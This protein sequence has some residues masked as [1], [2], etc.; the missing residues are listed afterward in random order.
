MDEEIESVKSE[1]ESERDW[2]INEFNRMKLIYRT[3]EGAK[4]F[5]DELKVYLRMTIPT[6]YAHWE[7]YCV[8][9]FKILINFIN[10]KELKYNEIK[11]NLLTH[12][13][14]SAYNKLKGKQS[15]SQRC[16][17]TTLFIDL[18][19]SKIKI[20]NRVDTKSNL[21]FNAFGEICEVIGIDINVFNEYKAN[22]DRLVNIRNSIAHGE[23]SF[24]ITRDKMNEYI[25][26]VI[27]LIDKV[28]VEQCTYID[29][30]EYRILHMN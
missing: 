16:E 7:G 11:N 28:L 15:F 22:I 13:N 26:F 4:G 20:E 2:R 27:E 1:L 29:Q 23:N 17:F 18:L 21:N 12:A 9:S 30:E 25:D 24:V 6:I 8:S 3:I 19:S 14:N 10:H 5:D